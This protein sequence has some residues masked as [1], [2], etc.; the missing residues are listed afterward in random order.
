[1]EIQ[2]ERMFATS[3]REVWDVVR[4][5]RYVARM[6]PGA[7][8]IEPAGPNRYLAAVDVG[9][10]PFSTRYELS[11]EVREERPPERL[12]LEV[13]GRGRLGHAGGVI[14]ITLDEEAPARTR[15]RYRVELDPG[16]AGPLAGV[17]R[18]MGRSRVES[19]L[20]RAAREL[21][22]RSRPS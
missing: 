16:T 15:L 22:R 20:D 8:A 10:G 2:G 9:L 6:V 12:T 17:F 18:R 14:R 7:E 4:D 11:I 21:E 1:V 19:A 5:P 13:A 3:R